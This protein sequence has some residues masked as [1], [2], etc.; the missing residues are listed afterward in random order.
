M[1]LRIDTVS[2]VSLLNLS[3]M[4]TA[5]WMPIKLINRE[6]HEGHNGHYETSA[7]GLCVDQVEVEAECS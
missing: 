1:S 2:L 7:P 6:T 5:D 3:W 4:L